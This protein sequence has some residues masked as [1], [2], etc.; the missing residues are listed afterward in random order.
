MMSMKRGHVE[1]DEDERQK[2]RVSPHERTIDGIRLWREHIRENQEELRNQEVMKRRTLEEYERHNSLNDVR[3][4]ERICEPM[5]HISQSIGFGTRATYHDCN[6]DQYYM[7]TQADRSDNDDRSVES[8][9]GTNFR[10][11]NA[12][13]DFECTR[14]INS[15]S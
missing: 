7:L 3:S 6:E 11:S 4:N 5:K 12:S 8:V 2:S 10:H 13:R 1:S 14:Q 15:A 9:N